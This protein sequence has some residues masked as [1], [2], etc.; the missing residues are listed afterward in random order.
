MMALVAALP[1]RLRSG[2][3]P[4]KVRQPSTRLSGCA[5]RLSPTRSISSGVVLA[6]GIG[7]DYPGQI[8]IA[9]RGHS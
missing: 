4:R 5:S 7:G 1:M 2:T 9:G 6:V 8:G 3:S